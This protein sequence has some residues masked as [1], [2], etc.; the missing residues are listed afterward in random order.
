MILVYK[1]IL[2]IADNVLVDPILDFNICRNALS[3]IMTGLNHILFV[4]VYGDSGIGKTT[5]GNL[6][7]IN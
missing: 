4:D 7:I 1:N 2:V 6:C 5:A 3:M